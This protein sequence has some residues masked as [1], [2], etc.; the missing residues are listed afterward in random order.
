MFNLTKRDFAKISFYGIGLVFIL[1]GALICGIAFA[2]W[3]LSMLGFASILAL[4]F[5]KVMGGIIIIGLGYIILE[6]ELLRKR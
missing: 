6:V 2:S 5:F 4:P 3:L 1:F